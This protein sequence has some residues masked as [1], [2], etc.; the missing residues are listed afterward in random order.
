M[1][2]ARKSGHASK[3]LHVY[4]NICLMTIL[5]PEDAERL[6]IDWFIKSKH[7]QVRDVCRKAFC[8]AY[9][10]GTT[11]LAN[12]CDEIKVMPCDVLS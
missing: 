2:F 11:A 4:N 12:I 1:L 5:G 7:F 8:V 9:G 3:V 6:D 10:I